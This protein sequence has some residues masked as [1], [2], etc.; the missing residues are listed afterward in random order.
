VSE[1]T[2][3]HQMYDAKRGTPSKQANSFVL[4]FV[5]VNGSFSSC[6]VIFMRLCTLPNNR[7]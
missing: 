1:C 2:D 3:K 4:L 6:I 5:I 7:Y